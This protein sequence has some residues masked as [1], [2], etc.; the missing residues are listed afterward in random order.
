M[1][2]FS[3]ADVV[4]LGPERGSEGSSEAGRGGTLAMLGRFPVNVSFLMR[5]I[6]GG[7]FG[8]TYCTLT[9]R[10]NSSAF[11]GLIIRHVYSMRASQ[12]SLLKSVMG[13]NLSYC[14][15]LKSIVLARKLS[16][17]A[18]AVDRKQAYETISLGKMTGDSIGGCVF[19]LSSFIGNAEVRMSS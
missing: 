1:S 12:G 17:I 14:V 11:V 18:I 9:F 7:E 15:P 8:D 2:A 16:G 10:M 4:S 3:S 13:S 6:R 19:S 5:G